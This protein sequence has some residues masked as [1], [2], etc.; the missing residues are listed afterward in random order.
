MPTGDRWIA[1]GR[2]TMVLIGDAGV[3]KTS[4]M[5]AFRAGSFSPDEEPTVGVSTSGR[6]LISEDKRIATAFWDTAGQERYNA[7]LPMYTRNAN[8]LIGVVPH[9]GESVPDDAVS[10]LLTAVE[11]ALARQITDLDYV[12]LVATKSDLGGE[13]ETALMLLERSVREMLLRGEYTKTAVG[14]H[15]ASAKDAAGV[16]S[17]FHGLVDL[18]R[19]KAIARQGDPVRGAC[20]TEV[21]RPGS[22]SPWKCCR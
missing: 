18:C 10:G 11:T 2:L 7:L 13:C 12:A 22:A 8:I 5:R 15:V 14:R 9:D 21:H 3:G 17:L 6:T 16:S 4:L 20:F 1:D 19:E